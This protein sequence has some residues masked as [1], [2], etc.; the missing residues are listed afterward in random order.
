[1]PLTHIKTT[2]IDLTVAFI[3]NGVVALAW[4]FDPT[5]VTF[6][7]GFIVSLSTAA[8]FIMRACH[9][10]QRMRHEQEKHEQEMSNRYLNND[11]V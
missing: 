7:G 11:D 5:I 3:S 10:A 1:M 8:F 4:T 2:A 9:E 6:A